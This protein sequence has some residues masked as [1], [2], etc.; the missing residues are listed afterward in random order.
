MAGRECVDVLG[1]VGEHVDEEVGAVGDQA[2][3]GG[4]VAALDAVQP[5]PGLGQ[6][7]ADRAAAVRDVDLP[8]GGGETQ[9]SR[10]AHRS[11]AAEDDGPVH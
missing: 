7:G 4:G 11:A 8:A 10:G 5:D 9:G 6:S 2:I 3:D 1:A